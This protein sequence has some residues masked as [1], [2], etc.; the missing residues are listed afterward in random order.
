LLSE[1]VSFG[2]TPVGASVTGAVQVTNRT[3]APSR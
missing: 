2:Q 1:G 3:R